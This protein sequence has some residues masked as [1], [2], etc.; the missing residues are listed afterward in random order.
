MFC[1]ICG[2][3][4]HQP[5]ITQNFYRTN[6]LQSLNIYIYSYNSDYLTYSCTVKIPCKWL[7]PLGHTLL[8][9]HVKKVIEYLLIEQEKSSYPTSSQ[10]RT[11]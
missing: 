9:M 4:S 5:M 8:F 3:I 10:I 2:A 11:F 7:I 6:R 1:N